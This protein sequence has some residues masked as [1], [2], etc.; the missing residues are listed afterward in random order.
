MNSLFKHLSLF[1]LFVVVSGAQGADRQDPV[2]SNR[3]KLDLY[4]DPLPAGAVARIGSIRF[5]HVGLSDLVY[6]SD[7][8]QILSAG[9]D[10]VLRWWDLATG[11]P[12]RTVNLQGN[13]GPGFCVTLSPDGK[14]LVAQEGQELIFWEIATGKELKKLPIGNQNALSYLYFSPDGKTLAVGGNP[15]FKV[16]LWDWGEGKQRVISVPI[17]LQGFN[18]FDSSNHGHFSHDGKIF[19]TGG[20]HVHPLILWDAATGREIRRI[21]CTPTISVFSPD[22]KLLAVASSKAGGGLSAFRLFVANTGKEL[23]H[24][25]APRAGFYWW[26]EFSPDMKTIAFLDQAFIYLLDRETLNERRRIPA[27]VRQVFFSADGKRLMGNEGNLIRVWEVET[28]KE[29]HVHPGLGYG[30]T[31]V[32]VNPDGR[33]L[34]TATWSDPIRIWDVETSKQVQ[35]LP[36]A[37]NDR[38]VQGLSFSADGK[39]LMAG[40]NS[41]HVFLWDVASA[42]SLRTV[43]LNDPGKANPNFANFQRM[44]LGSDGRRLTTL[45]R[46]WG[47][48]GQWDQLS[49]WDLDT[50]K[51]IKQLSLPTNQE[52]EWSSDGKT[53]AFLGPDGLTVMD[54]GTGHSLAHLAGKW[55][56]RPAMSPDGA[57]LAAGGEKKNGP[58]VVILE[59]ASGKQIK[60]IQTGPIH[61]C[62]LAGD[63]R[64][65]VT[66]DA[67][68][69]RVW[70]LSSQQELQRLE[71]PKTS[72]AI[73]SSQGGMRTMPHLTSDDRYLLT[74]EQDGTILIWDLSPAYRSKDSGS[75]NVDVERITGWWTDLANADPAIAYAAIWKLTDAPEEAVGLLQKQMKPAV[76]ADFDKVRKLIKELDDDRY[77]VRQSASQKL[78]K[79]GAGIQPALRHALEAQP[80]PEVR[81]RLEALVQDSAGVARSPDLLRYLRAI[82]VLEQIASKNARQLLTTL[83][84]GVPYAPETQAAKT[85]IERLAYRH[86]KATQ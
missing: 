77:E 2:S 61:S 46:T 76:D 83:A 12:V 43:Q 50:G 4:G 51:I 70:D 34:A 86:E 63:N 53:A 55:S 10:R 62:V 56:G 82:A 66:T 14:T 48:M 21:E 17:Q 71:L 23:V 79:M 8:K 54:L 45:E 80:P 72:S 52:L 15:I 7:G 30:P 27:G 41:G 67:T 74:P 59:T 64:T 18:G 11:K 3:Q 22:D 68:F 75:K 20:G 6:T 25:E 49:T 57:L 31:A 1:L 69:I 16:S 73:N 29:I 44:H 26:V 85:A 35:L 36:L 5:R 33:R 19:A 65:L 28:G 78:E 40:T 58:T 84:A 42:K 38:Y 24:K 13:S 32:A 37:E 9:G 60:E 47:P 81:R 39:I